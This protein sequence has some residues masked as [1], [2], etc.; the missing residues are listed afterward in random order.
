MHLMPPKAHPAPW[1]HWGD[2]DP[3]HIELRIPR[4][5]L[6]GQEVG[7]THVGCLHLKRRVTFLPQEG[8]PSLILAPRFRLDE[9]I[10][11]CELGVLVVCDLHLRQM[12]TPIPI[13]V[14]PLAAE[15]NPRFWLHLMFQVATE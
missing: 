4:D 7:G 6:E 9:F 3:H 13:C 2:V 8:H 10:P 5:K 15:D 14:N 11:R 12:G 1:Y